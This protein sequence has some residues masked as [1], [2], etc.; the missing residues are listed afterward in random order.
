M[1]KSKKGVFVALLSALSIAVIGGTAIA[2]AVWP[3][4]PEF[5]TG[6]GGV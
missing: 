5:P 6:R 4:A 2:Y 3:P 1:M